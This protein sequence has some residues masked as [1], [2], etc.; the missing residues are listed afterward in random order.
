ME[1]APL[2]VVAAQAAAGAVAENVWGLEITN[3]I[4]A[5][6]LHMARP[7]AKQI[8]RPLLQNWQDRARL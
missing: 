1:E 7:K 6:S 8:R 5:P 4:L 2:L 3:T